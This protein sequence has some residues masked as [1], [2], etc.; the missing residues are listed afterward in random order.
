MTFVVIKS[1][2]IFL[3][4]LEV[5]LLI[6]IFLSMFHVKLIKKIISI[7]VEPILLPIQ[8][9]MKHSVFHSPVFDISPIVAIL[10]ISYIEQILF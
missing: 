6:H 4:G 8:R 1:I 2:S 5:L 9:M 3:M 10:V 7:L